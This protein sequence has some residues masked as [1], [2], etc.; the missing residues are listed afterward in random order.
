LAWIPARDFIVSQCE[1]LPHARKAPEA[2]SGAGFGPLCE[3][4]QKA[5]VKRFEKANEKPEN[6]TKAGFSY[7]LAYTRT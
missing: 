1:T 7:G 6:G 5:P 3:R 2:S 4:Q